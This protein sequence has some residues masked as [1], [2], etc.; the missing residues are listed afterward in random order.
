MI[1]D[2]IKNAKLY[3][4]L[5]PKFEKAFKALAKGDF[6][7]GRNEIDEDLY[8]NYEEYETYPKEIRRFEAHKSYID[9]Q[10]VVDGQEKMGFCD[11]SEA[12]IL[13]AYDDKKDVMFL[14]AK[15]PDFIKVKNGYFVIFYP[16]DA[17]MPCLLVDKAQK[18]KK[19]VAKVK[20]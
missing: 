19:F 15:D 20:I 3:Y 1:T 16:N 17:H 18:V 6:N 14:S 11:V 7:L 5:H 10:F 4:S 13:E 2:K 9:I 8:V 12:E